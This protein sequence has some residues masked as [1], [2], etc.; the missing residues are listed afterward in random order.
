LLVGVARIAAIV[1]ELVQL[2][3][4]I[5]PA[6]VSPHLADTTLGLLFDLQRGLDHVLGRE[7]RRVDRD[8]AQHPQS[9]LLGQIIPPDRERGLLDDFRDQR[10][11]AGRLGNQRGIEPR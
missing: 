9:H 8:L 6:E 7:A 1:F 11:H 3:E 5:D 2:L 4:R 10:P